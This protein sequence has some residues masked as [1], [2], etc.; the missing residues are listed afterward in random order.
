MKPT[1]RM[2]SI[3]VKSSVLLLGFVSL[4][5]I[6][7]VEKLGGIL[8]V[9]TSLT[10]IA[11]GTTFGIF[12]LGMLNP[13]AT[14]KGAVFGAVCGAFLSG[15]VSLGSQAVTASGQVIPHKLP[16]S[17]DGCLYNVTIDREYPDESEVFP[18]YRLSYHWINPIGIFTVVLVGSLVSY[19]T[20]PRNLEEI[21]PELIS[22]VIHK[23]LPPS[24]FINYG[25][26]NKDH[27]FNHANETIELDE[28]LQIR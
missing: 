26:K 17:V 21:D 6:F 20:G 11:A 15:W 13:Y 10:A 5:L 16:V 22:P 4:G 18:L 24:C 12:T 23:L 28:D 7:V 27:K 25:T 2:A 8:G 9:A 19:F 14:S 3:F 1:E